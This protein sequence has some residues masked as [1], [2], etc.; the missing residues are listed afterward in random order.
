[1]GLL[2]LY[3]LLVYNYTY[4]VYVYFEIQTMFSGG[5]DV[6]LLGDTLYSMCIM[7]LQ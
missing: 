2:Y 5:S 6:L 1:M 3:L 7:Y 4:R